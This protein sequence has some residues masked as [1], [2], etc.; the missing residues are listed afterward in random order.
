M[1]V[2]DVCGCGYEGGSVCVCERECV[3]VCEGV[4]VCQNAGEAICT[5]DF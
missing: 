1:F 2:C 5:C 4:S 3:W